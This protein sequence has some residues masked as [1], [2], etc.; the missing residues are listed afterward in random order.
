[1]ILI[2]VGVCIMGISL[3]KAT[4]ADAEELYKMQ[5]KSFKPL[6]DKYQDYEVNP[7][8]EKIDR[9]IYRLNEKNSSYYFIKNDDASIGAIRILD[10]DALC[11]LKQMYILPEHQGNGY[12]QKAIFLEIN[13]LTLCFSRFQYVLFLMLRLCTRKCFAC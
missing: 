7:G 2:F 9:T 12:A 3:V 6:L 11:M 4:V 8:A 13:I 5:I 10:F 1:M